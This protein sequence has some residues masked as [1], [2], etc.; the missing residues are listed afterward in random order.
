MLIPL[1]P[2]DAGQRMMADYTPTVLKAID[3]AAF[4]Q[5]A[6]DAEAS[7]ALGEIESRLFLAL[8]TYVRE[9]ESWSAGIVV[10]ATEPSRA[11]ALANLRLFRDDFGI[12]RDTYVQA[13]E[14]C[15]DALQLGAGILNCAVRGDA[16]SFGDVPAGLLGH[17]PKARPPASLRG[18]DDL[19]NSTKLRWF[20]E[21]PEWHAHLPLLLDKD[22]RNSLGHASATHDVVTGRVTGQRLDTSYLELTAKVMELG[23][24][25]LMLLQVTKSVRLQAMDEA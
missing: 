23:H 24:A 22:L 5:W 3:S 14:T 12:L 4:G 20:E 13:F 1:L 19:P 18:F 6:T 10:R 2:G 11:R 16:D 7:G 17:N 8:E 21:W 9:W 25:I 15:C